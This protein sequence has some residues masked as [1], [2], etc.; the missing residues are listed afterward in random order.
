MIW[1]TPSGRPDRR[2]L[3]AVFGL[4]VFFALTAQFMG[5]NPEVARSGLPRL[6]DLVRRIFSPPDLSYLPKLGVMLAQTVGMAFVATTVAFVLSLILAPLAARNTTPQPWIGFVCKAF[7]ALV[8]ALP[9]VVWAM[10]FV[11]AVGLGVLP[12]VMALIVT[13]VGMMAKFFAESFEVVD[14]K[15]IEGVA[16]HGASPGAV[17]AIAVFPQSVPD[18]VSHTLYIFDSNVR[19]A[20][21]LGFVGAGGIGFDFVQAVKLFRFERILMFIVAIAVTVSILDRLSRAIRRRLV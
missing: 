3:L 4:L 17:R 12:G 16:A 2:T 15:A 9:E 19:S 10:L 18:L 6:F 1:V 13:S 20:G 11:S 7:L 8:R 21:I 14:A 5:I